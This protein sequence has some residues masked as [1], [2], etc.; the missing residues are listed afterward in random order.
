MVVA[1][2]WGGG[3][4]SWRLT[5]TVSVAQGEGALETDRGDGSTTL[6]TYSG[7]PNSTPKTGSSGKLYVICTLP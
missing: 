5:G 1:R 2:G 7:P 3:G 4:G 6:W